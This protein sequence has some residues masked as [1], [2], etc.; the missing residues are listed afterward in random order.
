MEKVL[1]AGANG[2]TGRII[3]DRLK[4]HNNYTPVAMIRKEE[5]QAAFEKMGVDTVLQDLENDLTDVTQ[6][7]D[8]VIFAAGS[9]A[10]TGEDKTVAVD[11]EGAIKL[12]EDASKHGVRKFVMLSSMGA[13][14]PESHEKL[15]HYLEAK[16]KA[17]DHLAG[18]QMNFSIIRPGMLTNDTGSGMIKIGKKLGEQGKIPREDVAATLVTAL[19]DQKLSRQKVEILSGDKNIDSALDSI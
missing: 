11:Q 7:M 3:I 19:E 4:G 13:D 5:Q 16:K 6:G 2:T 17:D 18:K 1:V 15:R 8:K 10:D 9:G 12:I 14:D